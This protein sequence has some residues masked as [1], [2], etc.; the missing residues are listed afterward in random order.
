MW[1]EKEEDL[2]ATK[3]LP[4]ASRVTPLGLFRLPPAVKECN[5]LPGWAVVDV[6][7]ASTAMRV[8]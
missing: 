2:S 5:S 4:W 1:E 7:E 6:A 3:M 8:P